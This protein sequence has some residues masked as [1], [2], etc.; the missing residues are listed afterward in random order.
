VGPD[1][2]QPSDPCRPSGGDPELLAALVESSEDAILI[3][4][5]DGVILSWNP[6]AERLFGYSAEEVLGKP[7]AVLV[8]P[9]RI[10]EERDILAAAMAGSAIIGLETERC[11]RDGS[12]IVVSLTVSPVRD[13]AGSVVSVSVIARDITGRRRYLRR[14]RRLAGYTGHPFT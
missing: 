1:R 10:A 14:L 11:R 9:G 4:S 8:P 2:P 6:A 5:P 3:K 13:A 12:T 7:V